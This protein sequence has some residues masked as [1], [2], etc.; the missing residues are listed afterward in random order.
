[1]YY[2]IK[3]GLFQPWINSPTRTLLRV[4]SA[5]SGEEHPD[6]P[7]HKKPRPVDVEEATSKKS[8]S[9]CE[10]RTSTG[11]HLYSPLLG[12]LSAESVS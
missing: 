9:E 11:S 3:V 2:K 12:I 5:T 1:M 4:A 7:Y 6:I 8:G 10:G